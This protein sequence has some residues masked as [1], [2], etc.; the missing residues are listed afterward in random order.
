MNKADPL[1]GGG[2]SADTLLTLISQNNYN[3][4]Q[5]NPEEQGSF[6]GLSWVMSGYPVVKGT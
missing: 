3:Q 6:I 2:V 1:P 4:T 5:L